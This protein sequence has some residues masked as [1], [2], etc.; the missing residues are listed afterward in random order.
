LKKNGSIPLDFQAKQVV[1][2]AGDPIQRTYPKDKTRFLNTEEIA[3]IRNKNDAYKAYRYMDLRERRFSRLLT[4]E[5]FPF[6]QLHKKNEES[7]GN[8][9]EEKDFLSDS[10]GN[11]L[12]SE[13]HGELQLSKSNLPEPSLVSQ[14]D[15]TNFPKN[16]P[17]LND[18]PIKKEIVMEFSPEIFKSPTSIEELTT[19]KNVS[20]E[21][22]GFSSEGLE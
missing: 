12:L 5:K 7:A 13:G 20:T 17:N 4:R 19:D 2:E 10:N 14:E 9:K 6:D 21:N 8:P 1:T 11:N 22:S 18:A 16:N 15:Q 3:V